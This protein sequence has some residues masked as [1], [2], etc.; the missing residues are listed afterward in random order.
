M[1][2]YFVSGTIC[3]STIVLQDLKCGRH[4]LK[5]STH[6]PSK[7]QRPS[8]PKSGSEIAKPSGIGNISTHWAGPSTH[9]S[10]TTVEGDWLQRQHGKG[11]AHLSP[12]SNP[13][14]HFWH[15]WTPETECNYLAPKARLST[16]GGRHQPPDHHRQLSPPELQEQ[17]Q[18]PQTIRISLSYH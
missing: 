4:H 10:G 8:A 3:L 5:I 18:R 13:R 11:G 1:A 2:I 15:H 16:S 17:H 7:H 12:S 14:M 9:L 6:T